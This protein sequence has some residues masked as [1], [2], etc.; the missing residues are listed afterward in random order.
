MVDIALGKQKSVL[1]VANKTF[2]PTIAPQNSAK[3]LCLQQV[4][5]RF[6]VVVI[7]LLTYNVIFFVFLR[8]VPT[9]VTA[10]LRTSI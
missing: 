7:T 3:F 2:G 4:E 10:L 6:K 5:M 1:W 8:T 9:F